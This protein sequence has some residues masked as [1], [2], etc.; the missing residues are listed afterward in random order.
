MVLNLIYLRACEKWKFS[1]SRGQPEGVPGSSSA[2]KKLL[3]G[4]HVTNQIKG[5]DE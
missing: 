3:E 2:N 4:Y 5:L 1:T